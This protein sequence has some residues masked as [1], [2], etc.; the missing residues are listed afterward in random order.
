MSKKISIVFVVNDL[1]VGGVSAVLIDLCN[2]LSPDLYN[3]HLFILS[4]DLAMEGKMPLEAHV[5]KYLFNYSF[6]YNYS[7]IAY[8]KDAFITKRTTP[9]AEAI[10]KKIESI[11]P[12]VLH[13]HTLPRQLKIGQIAKQRMPKLKLVYTDHLCRITNSDYKW[14]QRQLLALAYRQFYKQYHLIAVSKSVLHYVQTYNLYDKT[15]I[16]KLLENSI[17]LKKYNRTTNIQHIQHRFVYVSRMNHHKGQNTLIK[18]W[19]KVDHKGD[20]QLFLIGPDET[21][22]K[23]HALADGD[24]SIVFT[25]SVQNVNEYLNESTVAVF[26]SQKEGLP[27]SLLE[28][29]AFELPI[30]VSDIPELTS[31]I[32]EEVEGLHFKVD[33]VNELKERMELL[34]KDK[35]KCIDLGMR[36]RQR[37]VS[38]C[39][40]NDPI[41]FH[42]KFYDEI[43]D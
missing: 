6:S 30:I 18:A 1:T 23:L 36:S 5:K 11:S 7:L 3:I 21:N 12:N 43:T 15:H 33:D 20:A 17:D 39:E 10:V 14:Y 22:G 8:L 24:Q 27:I 2:N 40:E 25:G 26:P 37:V 42:N 32:R 31:I 4:D 13:F 38:I 9:R 34:L 29:M 28:K 19:K 16:T 35:Q 41:K